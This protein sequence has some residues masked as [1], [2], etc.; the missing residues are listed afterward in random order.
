M[1]RK[2]GTEAEEKE[3]AQLRFPVQF[4]QHIHI[5]VCIYSYLHWL[6]MYIY[7]KIIFL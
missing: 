1:L 3:R 4:Y 2:S 7:S 6:Y 5:S